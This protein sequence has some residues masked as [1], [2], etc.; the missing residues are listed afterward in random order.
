[1]TAPTQS[2][3]MVAGIDGTVCFIYDERLDLACL[4]PLQIRRASHVEPD[5][6]GRW[7]SDLSPAAGPVLG[8]FERRSDALAAEAAWLESHVLT[9]LC[10]A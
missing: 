4:G 5:E 6:D 10:G 8:P 2:M 1:M 3:Q 7:W 9:Q